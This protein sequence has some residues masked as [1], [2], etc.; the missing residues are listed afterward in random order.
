M[1]ERVYGGSYESAQRLGEE[2]YMEAFR[3]G[4]EWAGEVIVMGD[5]AEWIKTLLD[6]NFYGAT[7]VLDWR[8][9]RKR[10]WEAFIPVGEELG[11]EEKEKLRIGIRD[12]L[13]RGEVREAI[14]AIEAVSWRV[15]EKSRKEL[16][17]LAKYIQDNREGIRYQE[18]SERGIWIGTGHVEKAID[19]AVCRR[20][21][22]RGM[23]WKREKADNLLA[24]RLLYLNGRWDEFWQARSTKAA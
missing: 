22:E 9:L 1:K 23:S 6:D 11:E 21:K 3:Q 12:T 16:S 13:W 20:Q 5:G 18:L 7:F 4:V 15:S 2:I 8:H 14:R 19:L 24:L 10:V 17:G